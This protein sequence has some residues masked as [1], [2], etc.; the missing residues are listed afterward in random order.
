MKEIILA[1]RIVAAA[2]LLLIPV[3]GFGQA[4]SS[5]QFHGTVTDATGASVPSVHIRA[6]Q[7]NTGQVR[8]TISN[9]D[10]SWVLPNLA[11]GPYTLDASADGFK[12]YVQSGIT[13]QVGNNIQINIALQLGAVTQQLEV[14]ADAAMVE[15]QDTSVS[16]VI[17]QR[18][19]VDL[20][21]NGRQAT[22]LIL[23]SGGAAMPPNSSRVITTHDYA[24][25][26]GVSVSGGQI[27]GNN[28]LLDG[29][30][31]NDSHSNV[32]LPFPF[33]DALQ[34]FSVQ[35]NGVSARYGVHP[36]S[37]VN[38]VTKSGSNQ[39]HGDLFEFVRNGD[40][41]ARNY[42]A[43]AQDTLRRNQF[44]GTVGAPVIKDKLF[45]FS[46]F[47]ATR[48][49]TAPPT[50][51][52]FVPT[53][54]ALGGDLSTIDSAACQSNHKAISVLDPSTGQPFPNNVIPTSRFSAPSQALLK[55]L[56]VSS[57]PCGRVVYSIPSPSDENQYIGRADWVQSSKHS[58]FGRYFIADFNNPFFFNG[59]L[60]TTTRSGLEERTQS[61]VI[62]D[63]YTFTP[64]IVNSVRLTFGRLA[65][66]RNV[67]AQMP[68]P[69][70]IGVNMFNTYPHFID[71]S[72][73]SRFT[74]GGGSNAPAYYTRDQYHFAD[75]L[76][77]VRGRHH[78]A[79]GVELLNYRMNTRN[80]SLSNG[81][82]TFNGS[83]SNDPLAD[84]LLGRPSGLA[85]ANPDEAGLRQ[86]YAGAYVQDDIK[87]AK[88]LNFHAGVRWEP[89][90]P[91]YDRA[92][93]GNYFSQAAFLA[94][95]KTSQYVNAPAGLLF[96]PDPG[97]PISYADSRYLD[98]A[99]RIGL[100]W[101]PT[102]S[103]KMS[104]RSSYGIF[105]DT[106]E[107]YLIAPFSQDTPWGSQISLVAP[108]GGFA[109]PYATYPG[110]NPFPTQI[111]PSRNSVFP[112]QG[113]YVNMPLNLH[114]PYVQQWDLSVERQIGRDWL[115]SVTYIGNK[116]TH[117]YS[118]EDINPAVYLPGATVGNTNQRRAL[119]LLNPAQ[120][121]YYSSIRQLDD[122]DNTNYN[123]LRL[124]L[125]HRFSH[126]FTLLS[127]YT[128]SHCL[129]DAETLPNKL[130]GNQYQNP[131]SRNADYGSC[132][133]DLRQN[134]VNSFVYE[135]PKLA[136]RV[137]NAVAGNWQLSF[138]ISAHSGFPF[139]PLTGIDASLTGIG[140]DRPNVVRAPYVRDTSTLAWINAAAFQ[141][142]TAG[143][144]GNAG[145]NSLVGPGFFDLDTNLTRLFTVHEKQRF[146][147]RF[148]FFNTLNHTNF[149]NPINSLKSSTFGLLQSAADPRILQF[150]LKYSF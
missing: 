141:A 39:I 81:E 13:L 138:L 51:I 10:G 131:Y 35:T 80:V 58:I 71:L 62:G 125:Q 148:E 14:T 77:M 37:V 143:T 150:A 135:S 132:D 33:P 85:D 11:V 142:N 128:Y 107:S 72:V 92:G 146:E 55:Q 84:F 79:Y 115:A 52:A 110:G 34:E 25:A 24:N 76:D 126:N 140:N 57:D 102:G 129:Q 122:G 87:L 16:Q 23:L 26:V 2:F 7:T 145:A 17:D 89:F 8:S 144:Y 106:P 63:Q 43:R 19:I 4:V 15:T 54:A 121:A 111:P 5:G 134:F 40:F 59:N 90:L 41:N 12:R 56:P 103:G 116:A 120:G 82:F 45:L 6:T 133:F 22:D 130:T 29:G 36:G 127:V 18:R 95:Q 65:I 147:L 112:Q 93:R 105:Y 27:N 96:H 97:I 20:P 123:G 64:T 124:S 30:D 83:L 113:A 48:I 75:D 50:S 74:I 149:A 100:A 9:T 67:P 38:V 1:T 78:L 73:T 104:I 88:G 70:S 53:Q 31:H 94:G 21:L 44:G 119:Y 114:H 28:Y 49:R 42:F 99:P 136:N 137:L 68:N 47:Q 69:V 91:E 3:P 32:N 118:S 98:F 61:V 117:M 66:N 86:W 60:L 109:N 139:M 101:D 46:G 108:A